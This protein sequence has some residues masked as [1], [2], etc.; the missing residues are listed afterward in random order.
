MLGFIN[1]IKKIMPKCS[2]A[3]VSVLFIFQL[4]DAV[5]VTVSCVLIICF[6]VENVCSISINLTA[7]MLF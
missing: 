3:Y 2:L 4:V 1:Y 5:S 6:Y 7:G